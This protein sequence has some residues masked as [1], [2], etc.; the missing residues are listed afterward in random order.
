M[1][2]KLF[3]VLLVILPVSLVMSQERPVGEY[4]TNTGV[5]CFTEED[6][7]EY[8][9]ASVARD[10]TWINS[11]LDSNRCFVMKRGL[12]ARIKDFG[13]FVHEIYLFPPSGGRPVAVFTYSENIESAR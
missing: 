2:A 1:S 8:T 13:F 6:L 10:K 7:D 12:K 5:A 4:A 3:L 11:L 9:E